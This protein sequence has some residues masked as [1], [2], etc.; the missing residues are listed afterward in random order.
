M[1]ASEEKRIV[2]PTREVMAARVAD[3]ISNILARAIA[4]QDA[5]TIALSGGS[6]PAALYDELSCCELDWK[7]VTAALVDERWV[8]PGA[9][10]SNESFVRSHLLK[11][12]ASTAGFAGLWSD[13]PSPGA[14]LLAAQAKYSSIK[15][16]FD[17]VVLG[18]GAD[19]HAASWFPHA[20]GLDGALALHGPRL[21][22]VRAIESEITGK[23]LDRMTLTLGAVK[24]ATSAFLLITG[25]EKRRV[26]D[27]ALED[28]PV[29]D[30]PVRAILRA[31]PDMWVCWA[32]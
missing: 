30:M 18:M 19:G 14:G 31:R 12:K 17:V 9:E 5:A 10:G 11:N 32:P 13:T 29:E 20:E 16:P 23:Y 24:E 26:F 1:M 22:A 15:A 4:E 25:E 27:R 6:T 28:G 3:I 21:A 8:A 2:F 7:K